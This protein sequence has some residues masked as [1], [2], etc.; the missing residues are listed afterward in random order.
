PALGTMREQAPTTTRPR[1]REIVLDGL[2]GIAR[3]P[4]RLAQVLPQTVVTV[5]TWVRRARRGEAMAAPFTAPRTSF[6]G[7]VTGHRAV[8]FTRMNLDDVKEV[9]NAFGT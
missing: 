1:D 2:V 7:T 6:N 8:A 3:R 5:P 4:L 9:E